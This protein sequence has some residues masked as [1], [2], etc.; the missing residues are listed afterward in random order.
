M[1]EWIEGIKGVEQKMK[2]CIKGS[3]RIK[4]RVPEYRDCAKG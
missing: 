3:E 4:R 1:K 2:V